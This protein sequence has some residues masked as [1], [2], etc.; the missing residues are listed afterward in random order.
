MGTT[1]NQ[2]SQN[3]SNLQFNPQSQALYNSLIQSAGGKLNQNLTNPFGG[4]SQSGKLFGLGAGQAGKAAQGGMAQMTNPFA[5]MM[6]MQGSPSG[7]ALGNL[8]A[9][10]RGAGGMQGAAQGQNIGQAMSRYM[11]GLGTGL[12]FQPQMIGQK[13]QAASQTSTGGLGTWLPQLMGSFMGM[14]NMGGK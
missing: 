6:A 2:T 1:N 12:S 11:A 8:M 13:G 9:G 5:N 4:A 7:G 3:A 10:A 14:A